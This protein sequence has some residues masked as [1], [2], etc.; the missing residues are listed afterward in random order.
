MTFSPVMPGRRR[1]A[2]WSNLLGMALVLLAANGATAQDS[3]GLQE[4]AAPQEPAAD[5]PAPQTEEELEARRAIENLQI[6]IVPQQK[7]RAR[8]LIE[9][10]PN[11]EVARIAR[12]LL[13]KYEQFGRLRQAEA[14]RVEAHEELIRRY[15]DARRPPFHSP[16]PIKLTLRNASR[17]PV[18][19]E[20]R[21]PITEWLGTNRMA[22]GD[23]YRSGRP[24]RVRHVTPS[25]IQEFLLV[26]GRYYVFRDAADGGVLLEAR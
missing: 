22:V 18:L 16:E 4:P 19:Y 10:Y 3:A 23:E 7:E 15:W 9:Q 1:H 5:A 24:V 21:T 2:P 14:A 13:D 17:R 11:S 26:P 6:L 20:L 25:G 8:E 12:E